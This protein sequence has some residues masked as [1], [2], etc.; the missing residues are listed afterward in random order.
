MRS[1]SRVRLMLTVVAVFLVVLAARALAPVG[2]SEA[3]RTFEYRYLLYT[4]SYMRDEQYLNQLGREGWEVVTATPQG[5]I[6][7]R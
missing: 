1:E 3:A 7:K 5:F 4:Q 6:L 2:R